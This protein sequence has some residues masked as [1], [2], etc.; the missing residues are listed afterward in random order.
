M[1][2]DQATMI[3]ASPWAQCM[4]PTHLVF[5][6]CASTLQIR[7]RAGGS[8]SGL[9]LANC[10]SVGRGLGLHACMMLEEFSRV[11]CAY[12]RRAAVCLLVEPDPF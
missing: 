7:K 6:I 9:Q 2:F 1:G 11:Q 3:L 5:V 10:G 12:V 8:N 4:H